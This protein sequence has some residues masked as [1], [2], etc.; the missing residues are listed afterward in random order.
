MTRDERAIKKLIEIGTLNEYDTINL[1]YAGFYLNYNANIIKHNETPT[2]MTRCNV[3]VV[4][5]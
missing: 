2:L 1:E 4:T 3:V 5:R